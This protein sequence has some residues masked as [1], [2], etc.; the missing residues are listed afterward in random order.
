MSSS[1]SISS[2]RSCH[3][4]AWAVVREEEVMVK[5]TTWSRDKVN[6]AVI[7]ISVVWETF[8][9]FVQKVG[10]VCPT[11]ACPNIRYQQKC[12]V[13]MQVLGFI[14]FKSINST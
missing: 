14:V 4:H 3:W 10:V 6:F 2:T 11:H 12:I 5:G 8:S 1:S 7:P 9:T 13:L